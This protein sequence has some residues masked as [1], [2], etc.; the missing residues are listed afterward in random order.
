MGERCLRFCACAK[1]TQ[2]KK[3]SKETTGEREKKNEKA[4]FATVEKGEREKN[5]LAHSFFRFELCVS[6]PCQA[7]AH[8]VLRR[9][10]GV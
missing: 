9:W 5:S 2:L 10:L 1:S 8:S 7:P 3:P 6:G 4:H